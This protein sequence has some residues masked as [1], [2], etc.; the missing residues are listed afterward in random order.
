MRRGEKEAGAAAA[1][2]AITTMLEAPPGAERET[3]TRRFN[4]AGQQ[5]GDGEILVEVI[6]RGNDSEHSHPVSGG[7]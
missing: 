4:S 5:P 6:R 1:A 7:R 3:E 2:T